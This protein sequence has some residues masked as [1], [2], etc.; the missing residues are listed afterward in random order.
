M[1]QFMGSQR[2]RHNLETEQ[3]VPTDLLINLAFIHLKYVKFALRTSQDITAIG[4]YPFSLVI[5]FSLWDIQCQAEVRTIRLTTLGT[6]QDFLE[7]SAI[8]Q[9]LKYC[10][11]DN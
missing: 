8:Q 4:P 3:Y 10:L 5:F 6:S 7:D 1:L 2:V 9:K 11:N